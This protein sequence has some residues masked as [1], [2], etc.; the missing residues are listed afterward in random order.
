MRYVPSYLIVLAVI[1]CLLAIWGPSIAQYQNFDHGGDG[2]YF[3]PLNPETERYDLCFISHDLQTSFCQDV[4]EVFE[5]IRDQQNADSR[6]PP[7][8]QEER[9]FREL[10]EEVI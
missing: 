3:S 2:Y 8:T 7:E 4:G 6:P 1:V 9:E 5:I 10:L